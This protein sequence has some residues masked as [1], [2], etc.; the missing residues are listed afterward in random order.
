EKAQVNCLNF[1]IVAVQ[2][3]Q[4]AVTI[5][6]QLGNFVTQYRETVSEQEFRYVTQG[7][8]YIQNVPLPTPSTA[9]SSPTASNYGQK[10]VLTTNG[11]INVSVNIYPF[12]QTT[13]RKFG[14]GVYIAKIDKVDLPFEGCYNAGGVSDMGKYPFVRYH[15]DLKFGW[16]RSK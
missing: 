3:F 2:P 10:N 6:D 13:G 5:Y 9:C 7:P 14:N 12:S 11:R 8:N 1:N 4:I 16:M 15:S